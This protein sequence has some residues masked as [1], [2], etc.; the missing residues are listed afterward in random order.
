MIDIIFQQ[1]L[2][3]PLLYAAVFCVCCLFAVNLG[4]RNQKN[5]LAGGEPA[6]E[7]A[8]FSSEEEEQNPCY[9]AFLENINELA[10]SL[11]F[12][13]DSND[14]LQ[15]ASQAFQ[16]LQENA[17]EQVVSAA[18]YLIDSA[19]PFSDTASF[20]HADV[21][22]YKNMCMENAGIN[23]LPISAR[24]QRK[25]NLLDRLIPGAAFR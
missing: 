21:D 20:F 17:P 1:L 19:D 3:S 25:M 16:V 7:T 2:D 23:L 24:R 9:N 4:Y 12:K 8:E 22:K 15:G 10:D 18:S 13:T 5:N 6:R 11:Y 14:A